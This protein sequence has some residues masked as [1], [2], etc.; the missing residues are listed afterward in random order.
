[1][2]PSLVNA[3]ENVNTDKQ[4]VARLVC[5]IRVNVMSVRRVPNSSSLQNQQSE[6]TMGMCLCLRCTLLLEHSH[7]M[8]WVRGFQEVLKAGGELLKKLPKACIL[9]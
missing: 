4:H 2:P 7:Q 3:F 9:S 5:G 8:V 1:M 6:N